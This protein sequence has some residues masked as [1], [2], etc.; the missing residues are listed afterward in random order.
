MAVFKR[1][2]VWGC[3]YYFAGHLIMESSKST[4]KS[5]ATRIMERAIERTAPYLA[6]H[7][8]CARYDVRSILTRFFRLETLRARTGRDRLTL[9]ELSA[10]PEGAQPATTIS[11]TG[12]IP[13][14]RSRAQGGPAPCN[15][16]YFS[17]IA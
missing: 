10:V 1:G 4:S 5:L 11:A 2:E 16:D 17:A 8:D 7:A 15:G 12:S 6:E 13:V 14:A 9:V 3:K